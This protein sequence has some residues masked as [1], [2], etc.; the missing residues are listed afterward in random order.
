MT[1][2]ITPQF[3]SSFTQS[4]K[5]GEWVIRKFYDWKFSGGTNPVIFGRDEKDARPNFDNLKHVHVMPSAPADQLKWLQ[6]AKTSN[7]YDL[8]SDRFVLYAEYDHQTIQSYLLI[9]Y[10]IDAT[11]GGHAKLSK[12]YGTV[13]N[14]FTW[15]RTVPA[16]CAVYPSPVKKIA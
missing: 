15:A 16:G 4:P 2:F 7:T 14:Q 10:Y 6:K 8:T 1:L 5:T 3:Q 13:Q 12:Y 9:D 11:P